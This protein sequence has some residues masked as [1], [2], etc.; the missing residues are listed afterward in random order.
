MSDTKI[1]ALSELSVPALEDI[2]PIVDDPAGTPATVKVPSNRYLAIGAHI[3]EGRLTLTSGTPVTTSDVSAAGTLYFTPFNG[4]R[5]RI[6]DGTRWKLYTFTERSLSLTITSGSNYDVFIYDNSGTLTL[7]LSSAWTN[8]TT[9]ADAL[10]TQDGIYVKSGATTRLYLGTIRA[11]GSNV[12]EDS[13]GGATTQ[14]GGKRFVWNMYNR[15]QRDILVF[16]G[17][18]SWTYG[19]TTIRGANGATGVSNAVEF[20]RG[21]NDELVL[22]DLVAQLLA[23]SGSQDQAA[24]FGFDSRTTKASDSYNSG[25]YNGGNV[26]VKAIYTGYPSIGYHYLAWNESGSSTGSATFIGD[27][28]FPTIVM[29]GIRATVLG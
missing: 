28:N 8:D 2:L 21:M 22:G 27:D 13:R 7:E 5:I 24:F 6:F 26:L 16:E 23:T 19:S 18:N 29:N 1:S 12:T 10:T 17:A 25:G 20:V 9:R 3:V 4:N 15:V 14:V 11:S